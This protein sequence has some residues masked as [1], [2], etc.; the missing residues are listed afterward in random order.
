ML[1]RYQPV[2]LFSLR[3][4]HA[5]NKGGKTLVVPTPYAVKMALIDACFRAFPAESA[6][7]QAR[8]LFQAIKKA[9][10]RFRPPGECIVQNTF[11]KIRQ[12]ERD[13]ES[14]FYTSTIAYREWVY[15]QGELCIAMSIGGISPDDRALLHSAA[16][17]INHFGKRGC[18]WQFH[19]AAGRE[20]SL[21]PG[22][23]IPQGTSEAMRPDHYG[24]SQFLDDFGETLCAAKDGFERIST[25][26]DGKI[27]LG[28][29]R[30]L[31]PTLIPYVR[32][33][34]TRSFTQ[35]ECRATDMS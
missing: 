16:V 7:Q 5:T 26:H 15:F 3:M 25:Y 24:M 8:A 33:H 1:L 20:G 19:D 35:Y 2:S 30:V 28:Q 9:I 34:A 10:I 4:T 23:T 27:A 12:D 32:V 21:P 29:H 22:F 14:G 13:A 17:H 11:V 31:I 18:F 6:P